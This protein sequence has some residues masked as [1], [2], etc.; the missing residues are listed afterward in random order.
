MKRAGLGF[1]SAFSA[2][3]AAAGAV[4]RA[5]RGLS[6]G[7]P[8]RALV[9][10]TAAWGSALGELLAA[11]E[12]ELGGLDL[13]GASV[14]GVF[15]RGQAIADNPGLGVALFEGADAEFVFVE[16]LVV[17]DPESGPEI[18]DHIGRPL[19]SGDA[20]LLAM[21]LHH[22]SPAALLAGLVEGVGAGLVLGI[23]ASAASAG[24]ALVWRGRETAASG[25]LAVVLRGGGAV[26][27]GVARGSRAITPVYEVTRARDGWIGSLGS[28]PA[29]KVL[30]EAAASVHL[31]QSAESLR[32]LVVE[33][34]RGGK[35]LCPISG[36][37]LRRG[38]ILLPIAVVAGDRVRISVRDAVAA[39]ENLEAVVSEHARPDA[40]FGLYL[41]PAGNGH[42]AQG[43]L[44]RDARCF[45]ERVEP[46]PVLGLRASQVLGPPRH[47]AGEC[48][49][50]SDCS[51]L[52]VLE[53]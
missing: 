9:F 21:D 16:D 41:T 50:L 19:A 38:A 29:V 44:V 42:S 35:Q 11:V 7:E 45:H 30:R 6:A 36:V 25:V 47:L 32:Q 26:H 13:A 51:L 8:R 49:P 37:D 31:E 14:A 4:A 5:R 2:Q 46:F 48:R 33:V 40:S 27:W 43:D 15:A 22:R 39:R 17:D 23:G 3:A 1:S 52:A 34:D 18:L 10:A 24:D 28:E 20:L 53:D 12:G